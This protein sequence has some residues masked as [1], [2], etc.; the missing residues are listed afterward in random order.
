MEVSDVLSCRCDVVSGAV[1]IKGSR[2]PVDTL[3][4]YLSIEDFLQNF[5]TIERREA[6]AILSVALGLLKAHFPNR[7]S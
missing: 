7:T 1:V 5:P 3:F 6:E 2:V 4:D